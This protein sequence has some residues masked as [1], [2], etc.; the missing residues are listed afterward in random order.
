M[1]VGKFP[2]LRLLHVFITVA[3]YQGY[4]NAQQELNLTV[5]AISNYMSELEEKLGIILC[6]RGRGGFSLTEKGETVLQQ[7]IDLLN[8]MEDFER[9][10]ATLRGEQTGI[11]N[12]GV[13]DSTITDPML[14]MSDIIATFSERFPRVHINLQVKSPNALLQGVLNNELDIAIGTFSLQVNSVVS[15]PLYREQNWLYCGD[16]HSLFTLKHPTEALISEMRMV[17]RSY[18]SSSDLGRKGF[19]R[20]VASTESME[21]QLMLILSG[22]YVGYLPEHYALPWVQSHKLRALLPTEYGYQA[23]FSLIFRRGRSKE[24]LIRAMRDIVRLRVKSRKS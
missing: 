19:K 11:F 20:S 13:I 18:W 16:K 1:S 9:N 4:A 5:S 3:K 2:N 15:H 14:P 21:A 24:P 7:S 23:P 6:R 12:F 8:S 22:K 17:T 10:T